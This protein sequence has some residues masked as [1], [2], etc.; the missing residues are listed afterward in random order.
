VAKF[1]F[2]RPLE[3]TTETSQEPNFPSEWFDT[4]T[5]NLAVRI[6]PEYRTPLDRLQLLK[7]DAESFLDASLGYDREPD[8][9]NIQPD[10]RG[11]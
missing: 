1:T 3:V 8:R 5:Y 7:F 10:F 11:R 9:L 4:L 6:A 2:E